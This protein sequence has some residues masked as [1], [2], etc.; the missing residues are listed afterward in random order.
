M[1]GLKVSCTL[2]LH[3]GVL[4]PRFPFT[5]TMPFQEPT[6][7]QT[8]SQCAA[9]SRKDSEL[10]CWKNGTTDFSLGLRKHLTFCS[11]CRTHSFA[12]N[13]FIFEEAE[14]KKKLES[15]DIFSTLM[16]IEAFQREKNFQ[17]HN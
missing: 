12:L 11:L 5:E 14:E 2:E 1:G 8:L 10:C 15:S 7:F 3:R 6:K 16:N 13:T 17:Q 9:S 4:Q